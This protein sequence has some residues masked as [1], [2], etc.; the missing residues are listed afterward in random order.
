M[1]ALCKDS[2]DWLSRAA[3]QP[4]DQPQHD[5]GIKTAHTTK[6]HRGCSWDCS[7][8]RFCCFCSTSYWQVA[9]VAKQRKIRK[10]PTCGETTSIC[11]C[12]QESRQTE[13]TR[14]TVTPAIS[15][16]ETFHRN[17]KRFKF[18]FISIW[19]A[20]ITK[21]SFANFLQFKNTFFHLLCLFDSDSLEIQN[22]PTA[23]IFFSINFWRISFIRALNKQL[24][25]RNP[26]DSVE[27]LYLA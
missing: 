16:F 8:D 4:R 15:P 12:A 10:E 13:I 6:D 18:S 20:F 3:N 24:S 26:L 17:Q 5:S 1:N 25:L 19:F 7:C 2:I 27:F 11:A 14:Y 9:H 23:S 22:N 21:S